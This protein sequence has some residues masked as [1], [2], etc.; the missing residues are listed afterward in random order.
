MAGIGWAPLGGEWWTW[1][2]CQPV[3][4]AQH[5]HLP[6][7]CAPLLSETRGSTYSRIGS[8]HL[9]RC[10]CASATQTGFADLPDAQHWSQ[11]PYHAVEVEPSG[12]QHPWSGGGRATPG[13]AP[14]PPCRHRPAHP[15]A[16]PCPAAL[17]GAQCCSL[18]CRLSCGAQQPAA[19]VMNDSIA[20]F[21]FHRHPLPVVANPPSPPPAAAAAPARAAPAAPAAAATTRRPA[22][23]RCPWGCPPRGLC[24]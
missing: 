16:G 19:T 24:L 14:R 20:D 5:A 10:G 4:T 11:R 6:A 22:R 15:P 23:C 8:N 9:E 3:S 7:L 18:V 12:W 17:Q 1:Q 2:W 21:P 13:R